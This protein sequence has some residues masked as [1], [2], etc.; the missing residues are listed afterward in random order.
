MRLR[1]KIR[2][3][4]LYYLF[5]SLGFGL[6][7]CITL[8]MLM[9][10]LID[11]RE[12]KIFK[13]LDKSNYKLVLEE[14]DNCKLQKKNLFTYDNYNIS[15]YCINNIY[16]IYNNYKITLSD[17]LDK[18]YLTI[19]DIINNLGLM[20]TEDEINY[21]SGDDFEVVLENL[22]KNQYEVIFIPKN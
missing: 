3:L 17:A 12:D 8:I 18:N 6:M 19:S 22:Y 20:I 2:K 9:Y 11:I 1:N 13:N 5:F 16:I 10:H 15:G 14:K 4:K 7:I 21:Y